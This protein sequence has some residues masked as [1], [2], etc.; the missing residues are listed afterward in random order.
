MDKQTGRQTD[1]VAVH[2][3]LFDVLAICILL[4]SNRAVTRHVSLKAATILCSH[5][6]ARATHSTRYPVRAT[7]STR[8][9]VR[10]LLDCFFLICRLA[11]TLEGPARILLAFQVSFASCPRPAC[12]CMKYHHVRPPLSILPVSGTFAARLLPSA[13]HLLPFRRSL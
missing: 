1:T 12:M 7:H 6:L 2:E 9:P 8:N 5:T 10:V 3:S 11:A 4:F 13:A